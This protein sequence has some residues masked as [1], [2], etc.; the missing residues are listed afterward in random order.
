MGGIFINTNIM[1]IDTQINLGKANDALQVSL[2]RLAS[3]L[4]INSAADDASGLAISEKMRAQ[5][6]GLHRATL[7]AQDGISLLQT[8]EGALKEVHGIL[9]RMR[10]LA[11]QAANGTLTATD[12]VEIQ[13]EIQQLKAEIDR[14]S[15]A[16]E[17]NTKKLLNGDA[18]ALWST[19]APNKVE[20]IGMW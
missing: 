4:R 1:A 9:Q 15:T 20:A 13:K 11:V 6:S 10:E 3:G 18:A 12:R 8:A 17:F 5:I 16:T 2:K 19:D 14:I 7:N